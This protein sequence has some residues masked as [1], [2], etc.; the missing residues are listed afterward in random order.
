MTIVPAHE[1]VA[2]FDCRTPGCGGDAPRPGAL[3]AT[4]A[5]LWASR[6]VT[7][8]A[9]AWRWRKI[10]RRLDPPAGSPCSGAVFQAVAGALADHVDG[11]C[12][13]SV[14][15]LATD[16]RISERSVQ[17]GLAALEHRGVIRRDKRGGRGR[18]TRYQLVVPPALLARIFP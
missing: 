16:C 18:A 2:T 17:Y 10:V 15:C 11:S 7:A 5:S 12:F 6:R 14:C 3:C 13:P 9:T 1:L 4:C 8:I